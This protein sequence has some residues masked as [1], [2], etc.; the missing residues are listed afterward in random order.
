MSLTFLYRIFASL[1][2]DDIVL[3]IDFAS[4]DR[5]FARLAIALGRCEAPSTVAGGIGLADSSPSPPPAPA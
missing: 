1:G 4:L 3:N 5:A 2:N